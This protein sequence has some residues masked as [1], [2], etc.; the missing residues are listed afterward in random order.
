MRKKAKFDPAKLTQLFSKVLD[1]DTASFP[2]QNVNADALTTARPS[3]SQ[4]EVDEVLCTGNFGNI[5]EAT[6]EN[7]ALADDES[8]EE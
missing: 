5:A 6:A 7:N 4:T 1:K 2:G 3:T 8:D